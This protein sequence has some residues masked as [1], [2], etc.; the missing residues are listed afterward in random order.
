M[1]SIKA[2]AIRNVV[3]IHLPAPCRVSEIPE[4]LE[5]GSRHDNVAL[6]LE[7]RAVGVEAAVEGVELG[8]R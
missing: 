1:T 5:F 3:P 4:E 8:S 6:V 2:K 7:R